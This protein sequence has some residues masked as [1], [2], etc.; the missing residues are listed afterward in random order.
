MTPL[1]C[2]AIGN[3][4]ECITL[5]LTAGADPSAA[6]TAHN[7]KSAPTCPTS[8]HTMAVSDGSDSYTAFYC[9]GCSGSGV[10]ERWFC[11]ICQKRLLLFV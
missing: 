8:G 6:M 5:L 3:H 11:S 9:N 4:C 10:G 1:M 2:A 7:G